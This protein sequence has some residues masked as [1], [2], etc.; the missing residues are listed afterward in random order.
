MSTTSSSSAHPT[1]PKA[2]SL[3]I[4]WQWFQVQHVST[5]KGRKSRVILSGSWLAKQPLSLQRLTLNE[6]LSDNISFTPHEADSAPMWNVQG[7]SDCHC[8]QYEGQQICSW[9]SVCKIITGK[10]PGRCSFDGCPNKAT[11]GGHVKYLDRKTWYLAPICSPC[12]STH[13]DDFATP[14]RT[15]TTLVKIKCRCRK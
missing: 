15:G 12:N 13:S 4:Q 7:S 9:I 8:L 3:F 10:R 14:M 1:P 2:Q 6:Y 5:R 11:C